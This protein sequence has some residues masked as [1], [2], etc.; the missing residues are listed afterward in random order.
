MWILPK[1]LRTSLC[2]ADT[3]GLVW[4]SDKL[5]GEQCARSLIVR[6]KP[7]KSAIFCRKLKT[8]IWMQRLFS[9]TLKLSH[10][11]SFADWW[12][13]SLA[14][15]RVNLFQSPGA[16]FPT[17]I[18]DTSS[19]TSSQESENA[20]PQ[21][22]FWKTS[23]G[24]SQLKP[25]TEN[26]FS[27]MSSEA[28][29]AWV[30]E[31]RQQYARRLKSVRDTNVKESSSWLTPVVQDSKHS[32]TNPSANGQRD[33]LV[34]QVHW[35]TPNTLDHLP[36]RS[37]EALFKQATTSRK[38]RSRP[39]NLREQVNPTAVAI[40]KNLSDQV[41][42][43]PTPTARDHYGAS[44]WGRQ[45]RRGFPEDTLPNAVTNWPTPSAHEARLGYQDRRD[46][47]K[48]AFP[49]PSTRDYKGGY[50]GGRIRNGKVS[51][52]TLDVAVQHHSGDKAKVGHLNSAWVEKLMGVPM[53]WT[54]PTSQVT[55][56]DAEAEWRD[57]T[58]EDGISRVT[59]VKDPERIDKI[60]SLG[61]GVVPACAALAFVILSE[62]LKKENRSEN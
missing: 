28:W 57:G 21:L 15:S 13:S 44:G 18:P 24:S 55:H 32:G 27:N 33:L 51:F 34:N 53:G 41:R 39:A 29:K 4:D 2:A 60:R 1:N 12:T 45:E 5:W 43:W 49:T 36:Q 9:A 48:K 58:W 26:Q 23:R 6:A 40:Y 16:A 31:Q 59:E 37:D 19:L 25:E 17:K 30:T 14:A 35:A 11:A 54:S 7:S 20:S 8:D 62:R 3:K 61:N 42:L 10:S 46:H 22:C 38:G 47:S 50:Q 52:D 56:W